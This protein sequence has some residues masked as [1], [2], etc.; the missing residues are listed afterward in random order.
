MPNEFIPD[1][2]LI[3]Q[4]PEE[5]NVMEDEWADICHEIFQDLKAEIE[6]EGLDIRI[7]PERVGPTM[8]PEEFELFQ[9]IC[10]WGALASPALKYLLDRLIKIHLK[11]NNIK[12][13]IKNRDGRTLEVEGYN[14][15]VEK[16][17]E[18]FK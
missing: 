2:T 7:E 16:I 8:G 13:S 11:K 3:L 4:R 10:I 1:L 17:I 9:N 15:K 6:R 12:F 5:A 14:E 18:K